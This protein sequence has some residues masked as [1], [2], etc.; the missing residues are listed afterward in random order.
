MSLSMSMFLRCFTLIVFVLFATDSALAGSYSQNF[1]NGTVGTQTIGGGDTSTLSSSAN[2]ASTKI[3]V[4]VPATNKGLKLMS[5]LG[6]STA[7]WKMPDLDTG[8]EIQSF[9]A[10]FN[11]AIYRSSAAVPGA[12]WSL[13]FGAIPSGNGSGEGGFVMPNGLAICYDIFNNG[14]SDAPS[15]EIFCNGASVGNFPSATLTDPVL[16]DSGTFTLTNPATGGT[17]APIAF[18]ATGVQVQT[19][20]RAVAG[21]DLVA[22]TG[23][24]GGTWSVDHGAFGAYASPIVDTTGIVPANSV[25]FVNALT[26]PGDDTH[27]QKW[28]FVQR[29]NRVRAMS[30]HWDYNGLDVVMNGVAVCTDLPTPGFIPAVGNKFAFSGRTEGS[31][32]MEM[33]LDD[34]VL[35]TGQLSPVETGGPV[36]SEFMADNS[37]TLEDEDTDKPDWIEIYNG[38]STTANLSGYRLTNA[39]GNNAMWTIP[40]LVPPITIGPYAYRIIYASGKDRTAAGGQLHTNF[41][42]QKEAGYLALIKSDGVTKASQFNYGPQ[43]EDVSYGEKGQARTLGYFNVPTPGTRTPFSADQSPGGPAEDVVWSRDGGLITGSP[44]TV[45][46]ITAPVAANSVVRYTTDNTVPAS[47]S[48][49]YNPAS[50]PAAFSVTSSNTLRAR[51]FTPNKLPGSVSSRTFLKIDSSLTNYNGSGLPFS[52]NLPIVVLDSFGQPVDS[53]TAAGQRDYR[54]TYAVVISPNPA[55]GRATITD[56]PDFQGRC[57]TH[58]RGESSA[59]FPQRQYSWELWDNANND[60]DA[61][62]LGLPANSDWILYAPWSDKSLMRDVLIFGTMRKLRSDYMASRTKFCELIYNQSAGAPVAY[63]AS[64]KGIYAIKEKLKIGKDRVDLE[65]LN[66]LTTQSPGVAGGYIFRKD[67]P[68]TDATALNTGAFGGILSYD[69]DLLNTPQASS[70]QGYINSFES[71]LNS[72][73]FANPVTGYAAWMEVDTFIDAQWFVEWTKQVDGYVFSTY[74][75]KDRNGRLRA[76]PIWDFNISLGNADYATGDTPTGWLYGVAGG[77]GQLWYPRLHQDPWYRLRHFDRYWELRRGVLATNS[78]TADIDGYA[79]LLLNGS[80]TA[81]TNSMAPKSPVQENAVMRH[82][83]L[84]P[85]LAQYDWPNG[86]GYSSRTTFQSEV[87]YLKTFLTTRLA[88]LDNQNFTGSVIYR[89]PNFSNY[90]GNVDMGTEITITPFTGTP[91][92]GF[93]YATG[94]LYYTTDG[95]DPRGTNG[96]AA[97][98]IYAGP[99]TLNASQVLNARLY[100]NGNWSPITSAAY[101]VGAAPASIANLVVSE[102]MYDPP[103]ASAAEIS[104]GYSTNDF[105]YIELLNVGA[106]SIDLTDVTFTTGV[107]FD[108]GSNNPALLTL[109]PGGRIVVAANLNAFLLRYGNNPAVRV[110]SSFS[111]SLA[112]E[113]EPITLVAANQAIIAEFTYGNIEPWPVDAH[114]GTGYSLVLNNPAPNLTSVYYNNGANWRSS[115][116]FNG[117][118]GQSNGTTFLGSPSGDT[119]GDG[120]SDYFEYATGSN[121]GSPGSF[122]LPVAGVAAYTVDDVTSNY[123]KFDY[124]RNLSADGVNYTVQ[125]S[126]DLTTWSSDSSAVVYV[127]THNNGD[128]TA[129]VTY[130]AAAPMSA[131]QPKMFLRLSV[132]P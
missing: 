29:S 119:D 42:L 36:I 30:I 104:A 17:T 92:G 57:G 125:S 56:V 98:T 52:T 31:N 10:N 75:H 63:A 50:P 58:V 62:I 46:T 24:A 73:S 37:S 68:D 28:S 9:D 25:I 87:T 48:P 4:W 81:V 5:F 49:I 67:K 18:N 32:S 107:S 83:R 43:Y 20:M 103:N 99:I 85:R 59:G 126:A 121:M 96:A 97:G 82:Y 34:V 39:A 77:V 41:T 64:Y 8:K 131:G 69:P 111:G 76:G 66:N 54:F 60:K 51:V 129:T 14:G 128:G 11:F 21:W 101:V 109:S 88:W 61:S 16:P 123:L 33:F 116:T 3:D 53:Y 95:T 78:I 13:N 100:N 38:Q 27:N 44:A 115:G 65:K 2:T 93:T 91:P 113:G 90:G 22:V 35:T 84:F 19:A 40:T 124:R 12:G 110:A 127:G 71:V 23:S 80:G 102:I 122:N 15:I 108:F 55:T 105:E 132:A 6:G 26:P 74:F 70:L 86:P 7:S 1:V 112:N 89:P 117:T 72:G 120:L 114:G 79:A 45:V 94:A 118:P 130:R 47:G 106:S